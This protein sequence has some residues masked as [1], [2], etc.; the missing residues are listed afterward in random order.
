MSY[1]KL[2]KTQ[3]FT[4]LEVLIALALLAILMSSTIKIT[5]NNINNLVYLENKTLASVIANNHDVA[6]RLS[7]KKPE[8]TDGWDQM[9]GRRWY[10]TIKQTMSGFPSVLS[11]RIDVFLEGDKEPLVSL[12]S[13]MIQN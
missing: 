7:Q 1:A 13:H 11:Y 10:W 5:A 6:L 9:S 4:L 12:M 2:K 8:T 3:G